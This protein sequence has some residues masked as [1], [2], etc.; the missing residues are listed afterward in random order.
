MTFSVWFKA[1]QQNQKYLNIISSTKGGMYMRHSNGNL[2]LYAS[3]LNGTHVESY[4]DDTM[5]MIT[6]ET[7]H[8]LA[9]TYRRK[10]LKFYF[11]GCKVNTNPIIK[12]KNN[13]FRAFT[14][15]CS[16]FGEA[17]GTYCSRNSY[18]DFR[19]WKTAKSPRFIHWL[20]QN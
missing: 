3:F 9:F 7:W 17:S 12:R 20:W 2:Q 18:D 14:M 4:N 5:P 8:L 15:G 16:T 1:S 13:V 19:F 11:D 10:E 6:K